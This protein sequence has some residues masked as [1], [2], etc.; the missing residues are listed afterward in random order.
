M[1][2]PNFFIIGNPKCGTTSLA[3]WLPRN[4]DIF[5]S[6]DKEPHYFATDMP[7]R[8]YTSGREYYSLFEEARAPAIGE[9][10]VW[11]AYSDEAVPNILKAV[12][13][14]KFILCLR[15]P[16]DMAWALHNQMLV[17]CNETVQEFTK[18][19][20]MS[21]LRRQ[22][23]HVPDL[24][25]DPSKLDYVNACAQGAI[26]ERLLTRI[27]RKNLHLV[28]LEDMA[29]DPASTVRDIED[30]LN[31]PRS[32]SDEFPVA[33]QSFQRKSPR[34]HR[35]V[36]QVSLLKRRFFN[37]RLKTGILS[38]L[39]TVNR[40]PS[41]REKISPEIRAELSAFFANDIGLLAELAGRDLTHWLNEAS[42]AK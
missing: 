22:G 36:K 14:A 11:Y 35:A 29:A 8:A 3:E 40:E 25:G 23:L 5:I 12:P 4:S 13:D 24:C 2:H 38:Y 1:Q 31:V 16:A 17:T 28:F 32:N 41:Q 15:H 20:E 10:S 21:A 7:D 27:G 34:L 19:W 30:F 26:L 9:A 18:A 6:R 42:H 33:N 39:S 37:I